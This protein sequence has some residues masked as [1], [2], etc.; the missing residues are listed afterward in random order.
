M[1]SPKIANCPKCGSTCGVYRYDSGTRRVECDSLQTCMYSGPCEGSIKAAIVEH[2][3]RVRD[4]AKTE[5]PNG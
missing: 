1:T 2:N 3:K 5:N 4:L